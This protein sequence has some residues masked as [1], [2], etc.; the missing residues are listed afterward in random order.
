LGGG[1]EA[2]EHGIAAG[3]VSPDVKLD[4]NMI[5]R[6]IDALSEG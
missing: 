3:I 2:I 6:L 4:V 5:P 1:H